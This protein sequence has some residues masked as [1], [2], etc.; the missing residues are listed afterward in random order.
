MALRRLGAPGRAGFLGLTETLWLL[1]ISVF[2][3]LFR[4]PKPVRLPDRPGFLR[5]TRAARR[6]R[7]PCPA[8]LAAAHRAAPGVAATGGAS[9]GAAWGPGCPGR[10]GTPAWGACGALPGCTGTE[11][12]AGNGA[13]TDTGRP[14]T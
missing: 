11:T 6:P 12:S 8:V 1:C 13:G 9:A 4:R 3:R 14:P 7:S 5:F 2:G 10:T